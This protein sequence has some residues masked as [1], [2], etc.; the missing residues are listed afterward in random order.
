MLQE[1]PPAP[2][3]HQQEEGAVVA[4]WKLLKELGNAVGSDNKV[5]PP[6]RP[7]LL[8]ITSPLYSPLYGGV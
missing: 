5:R 7:P 8:F 1:Q 6:L 3:V 4:P 2:M